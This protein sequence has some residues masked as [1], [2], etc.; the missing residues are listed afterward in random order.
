VEAFEI[1]SFTPPQVLNGL[2]GHP[3]HRLAL[4]AASCSGF[5]SMCFPFC[6]NQVFQC[7]LNKKFERFFGYFDLGAFPMS[8]YA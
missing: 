2:Q 4:M 8:E 1:F 6:E 3:V 5:R 7:F